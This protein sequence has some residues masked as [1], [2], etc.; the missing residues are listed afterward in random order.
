LVAGPV[1]IAGAA[2]TALGEVFDQ[3][4]LS[5]VALAAKEALGEAGL[6][7][8]DVDGLFVNYMGEQGSVQV[9]EYL[10]LEP[11]YADSSDLGGAAFEASHRLCIPAALETRPTSGVVGVRDERVRT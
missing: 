5:M 3:T 11:R 2:E 7:I 6:K 8:A 1:Y 9:G 4:E 10:G